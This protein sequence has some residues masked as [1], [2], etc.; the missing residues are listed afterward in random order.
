MKEVRHQNLDTDSLNRG[1]LYTLARVDGLHCRVQK[2]QDGLFKQIQQTHEGLMSAVNE[3]DGAHCPGQRTELE[4]NARLSVRDFEFFIMGSGTISL[5]P[6]K[7]RKVRAL[8][9]YAREEQH[10]AKKGS[11]HRVQ[12]VGW[13]H[14]LDKLVQR[15]LP[16]G[17]LLPI[18][19]NGEGNA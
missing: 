10:V 6:F 5:K 1:H 14:N 15:L 9:D 11:G 18:V 16:V 4:I 17:P 2:G 12:H 13:R 19:T 8:V 3:G 7:S